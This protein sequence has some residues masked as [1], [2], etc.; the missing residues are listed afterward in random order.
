MGW[1]S[2]DTELHFS[3]LV[4]VWLQFYNESHSL[5]LVTLTLVK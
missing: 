1:L 2:R 4:S 5:K 3:I